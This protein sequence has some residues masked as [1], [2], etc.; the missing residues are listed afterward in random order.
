MSEWVSGRA[1][2]RAGEWKSERVGEWK[3]ER[4]SEWVSG[5]ASERAYGHM[6]SN[7]VILVLSDIATK[8]WQLAN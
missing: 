8:S 4:A 5:R 3:S 6:S 7:I 1:S 2:K